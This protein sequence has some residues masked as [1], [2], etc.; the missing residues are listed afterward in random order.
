MRAPKRGLTANLPT[1]DLGTVELFG[2]QIDLRLELTKFMVLEVVA[3][4]LMLAIFLPLAW[5]IAGGGRPRG[6]F[7][8][9]FEVILVFLRDEVAR[10]AIGTKEAHRFLPFIWNIFFFV[11]FCNLLGLVPRR[12]RRPRRS[13]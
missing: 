7:W 10:P 5:R 6:R 2:W 11:L 8:N 4:L 3:A 12:V 13:A 1:F 9:L